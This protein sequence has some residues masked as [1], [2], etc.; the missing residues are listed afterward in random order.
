MKNLTAAVAAL[1]AL[2]AYAG[3]A[4]AQF[5]PASPN[6]VV[7]GPPSG[8]TKQPPSP[9]ALVGADLPQ[10][11][12]LSW[13]A[14]PT[15]STA[16]EQQVTLDSTLQWSGTTLKCTP[17]GS[18]Q[19]GCVPSSGGGTLNF[20]RADGTWAP[21]TSVVMTVPQ[22]RLTL[23]SGVPVMAPT[24]CGGS[25]CS[26]QGTLYFDAYAGPGYVPYYNGST[27]AIDQIAGG[28]VSSTFASMSQPNDVFDVWWVH[29]GANRICIA[30]NGS[31]AGWAGDTGGSVTARGTG[32]TQLSRAR[33]YLTNANSITNC[34]NNAT[35]Y[36]PVA[37][38]Q[39]TYLGTVATMGS[40]SVVSFVFGGSGS[41]GG[42]AKFG[43][44]NYYNR[45]LFN[46]NVLDTG[47]PYN[48]YT[49]STIRQA[50]A[51]T[52]NQI[53]IVVG[54]PEDGVQATYFSWMATAAAINA[55]PEAGVGLDAT[56]AFACAPAVAFAT[57]S[58]TYVDA[59]ASTCFLQPGAGVHTISAN[60][61]GDGTN[62][63]TFQDNSQ[64]QLSAALRM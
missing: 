19:A 54:V 42:A 16:A 38:N 51:S 53:Q 14:N 29:S 56:N 25:P 15:G 26:N 37:A 21:P 8:V 58:A 11:N 23:A 20:L 32:Y 39:A 22:G 35:Q 28:E 13:W 61:K 40:S 27:D 24:S 36:G 55:Q 50:R 9:R 43:V 46:T 1:A 52:G 18:A 64:S 60:E 62:A 17:F 4:Y 49:S 31:G 3:V 47:G 41:G 63:N 2:C 34:F 12:A 48:T 5:A 10:L 6:T 57:T 45:V 44:W 30:T 33:G 59:T 7:A